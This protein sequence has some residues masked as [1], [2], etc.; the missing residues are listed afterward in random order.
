M[1]ISV[2]AA[3]AFENSVENPCWFSNG[4]T[5]GHPA[6]PATLNSGP[7]NPPAGFGRSDALPFSGI[8]AGAE[9]ALLFDGLCPANGF[10][11]PAGPSGRFDRS[12]GPSD[13]GSAFI[14]FL[15]SSSPDAFPEETG[16]Q[17]GFTPLHY[18][19]QK[20]ESA[21]ARLLLEVDGDINARNE[22]GATPMLWAAYC[23]QKAV[24]PRCGCSWRQARTRK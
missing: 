10:A 23:G 6:V 17:N 24:L 9:K 11:P 2:S 4:F 13:D 21:V 5:G 3:A 18:A 22:R 15:S 1:G 16:H 19:S 14:S 20:G 7:S 8:D 12:S